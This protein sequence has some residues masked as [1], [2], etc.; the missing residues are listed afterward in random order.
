MMQI[1]QI[2]WLCEDSINGPVLNT[3]FNIHARRVKFMSNKIDSDFQHG[4][5]LNQL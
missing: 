5:A 4:I 3:L 1:T 2:F